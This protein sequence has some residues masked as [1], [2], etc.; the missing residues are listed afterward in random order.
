MKKH[1]D[2]SDEWPL[3]SALAVTAGFTLAVIAFAHLLAQIADL[4]K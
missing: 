1:D 2:E 3:E 4:F